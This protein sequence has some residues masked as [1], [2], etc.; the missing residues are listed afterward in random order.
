MKLPRLNQVILVVIFFEFVTNI[1]AGL[2][3]PLFAV[4][5]LE[6]IKAP[7][8]VVGFAVALYWIVKS[9]LQ[10]PIARHLDRNHGEVDDYYSMVIGVFL[11]TSAVFMYYF[12]Y[13]IWHVYAL[14]LLIAIGDAFLVPPFYAIFTRHVDKNSEGF[15]WAIRSSFSIGVGSAMGGALAGILAST[16]GIRSIFLVNGTLMFI[17]LVILLFLKP[18]IRPKAPVPVERVFIEQ[19]RI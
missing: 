18:Y 16:I 11:T 9:I 8:T 5:V 15:E 2:I 1:A 6:D 17:G 10:L 3:T 7:V 14:Q 19:K 13:E 4:F 12:A